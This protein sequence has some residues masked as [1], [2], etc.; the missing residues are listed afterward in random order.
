MPQEGTASRSIIEAIDRLRGTHGIAYPQL[1]V[2]PVEH[3]LALNADEIHYLKG[4]PPKPGKPAYFSSN[5]TY[6]D[7]SGRPIPN[8][9]NQACFPVGPDPNKLEALINSVPPEQVKPFDG[10]TV[11][12]PKNTTVP[13]GPSKHYG[14]F[15]DGNW[16]VTVGYVLPK[17]FKV[18]TGG[19]QFQVY[20]MG[21]ITQGGGKYEG[22]RGQAFFGG[23]AFFEEW[24]DKVEDQITLFQNGFPARVTCLFKLVLKGDAA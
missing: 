23:S 8:S 10:L 24:P 5:G 3:V 13:P 17:V 16:L 19:A 2:G 18:K 20:G 15:G 11:D 9:K 4:Y 7:L 1:A 12:D 22:A 14:F 6:T 21:V